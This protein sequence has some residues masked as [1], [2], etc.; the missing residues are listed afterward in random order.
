M[1]DT[2]SVEAHLVLADGT[3]L[4]GRSFGHRGSV[5]G[6]VVCNTGRTGYQAVITDPS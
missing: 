3:V 5:V 4:S 1:T 6:E 2:S